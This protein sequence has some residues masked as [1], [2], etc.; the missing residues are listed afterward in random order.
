MKKNIFLTSAFA[1][2]FVLP[3]MAETFPSNGLMTE[4]KT[5]DNAATS[6]NMDGVYEGTVNAVAEY[7]NILYQIGAGQYLP[8]GAESPINCNVPGSFCPGLSQDVNYDENNSQGL[9]SCSSATNG[10]YTLSDGTGTTADSCYRQCSGNITIA[11][12]TGITGNDYYGNGADTCAP[13]GCDN[14]YHIAGGPFDVNANGIDV[15]YYSIGSGSQSNSSNN[16]NSSQSTDSTNSQSGPKRIIIRPG[17]ISGNYS[18]PTGGG[19]TTIRNKND[20][21][22]EDYGWAVEFNYG[23]WYGVSGVSDKELL[24]GEEGE[25][26]CSGSVVTASTSSC[27][28]KITGFKP[29]GGAKISIDAP[30]RG[31]TGVGDY[32]RVENCAVLCA[33]I[34]QNEKNAREKIFTENIIPAL[35]TTFA[36]GA[37]IIN[38][39]WSGSDNADV[40]T[41]NAE[42]ARYDG[43]IR[44]PVKAQ[45]IKGKTFKGWRFSKP[46]TTTTGNN[47]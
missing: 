21:E 45:T 32:G 24:N 2:G 31:I 41:N 28:C 17:Y 37:N 12:A 43:N 40:V 9:T 11:H 5:Y 30:Y 15:G 38:V 47:G 10:E 23:T 18:I 7:E 46:E 4:N 20:Y 1:M 3:A 39:N 33:K 36:C 14:G 34:I 35:P 6:T 16:S 44:T 13:T 19:N 8:A 25:S 29:F 22:L 27:C 26:D 42:T